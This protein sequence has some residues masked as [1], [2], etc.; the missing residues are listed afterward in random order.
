MQLNEKIKY[1]RKE[2]SMSKKDLAKRIG[3]PVACI[4]KYEAG[5]LKPG[6]GKLFLISASL[7]ISFDEL[8]SEEEPRSLIM[9]NEQIK[10]MKES[11]SPAEL[12]IKKHFWITGIAASVFTVCAMIIIFPKLAEIST[13]FPSMT[14]KIFYVILM[15]VLLALGIVSSLFV[16]KQCDKL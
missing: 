10:A 12:F 1:Y 3:V 8:V 6:S 11:S 2:A 13:A 4:K 14:F 16:K 15:I 5:E 7:G 9:E